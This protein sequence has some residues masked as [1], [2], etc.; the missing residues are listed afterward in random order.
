[1]VCALLT[2]FTKNDKIIV[3]KGGYYDVC[4]VIT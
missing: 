4:I 1:M 2:D 3:L